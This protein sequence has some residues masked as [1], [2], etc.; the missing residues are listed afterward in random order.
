MWYYTRFDADFTVVALSV[1][2]VVVFIGSVGGS[3]VVVA[4][5]GGGGSAVVVGGGVGIGGAS[6]VFGFFVVDS[7]FYP[8]P[9]DFQKLKTF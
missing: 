6:V 8:F 2:I 1:G 4:L 9:Y 5:S 3:V 7:P